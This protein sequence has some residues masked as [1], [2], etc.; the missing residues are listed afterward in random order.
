MDESKEIV[1]ATSLDDAVETGMAFLSALFKPNDVVLLRPIES[2]TEDDRKRSRV[3]Y[4]NTDYFRPTEL[5]L[6]VHL[7]KQL[8]ASEQNNTNIFFGTCPRVGTRGQ[9]DLA[10]QIRTVRTLWS[11]IDHVTVDEAQQ[12]LTRAGLPEPSILVN[13]GNGVHVYWLLDEPYLI[14]DAGDPHRVVTEWIELDGGRKKPRKYIVEEG[15]RVYLDHC[16]HTSRLSPKAEHLQDVLFGIAQ[17]IDGDHTTDLSRLLRI[18]G[19]MNRK[20]Q[21]NGDKPIPSALIH[22]EP[23]RMYSLSVFEGLKRESPGTKKVKK[24][25]AMPLPTTR[26]PSASKS[27]RLN[28]LVAA[29]E[30]A[31]AGN[32][33][34]ADFAVCC[35]AIRSGIAKDEVW[36]RVEGVGK[37]A[38]S[39]QRYFD[40]TWANAEQGV[41]GETYDRMTPGDTRKKPR[42]ENATSEPIEFE[43]TTESSEAGGVDGADAERRPTICVEPSSTPV[44]DT[45]RLIT[46]RLLTAGTC[47]SRADQ[48]V[49]VRDNAITPVLS[50]A[51]LAGLLNQYV[52]FY[53][54]DGEEGQYKPLPTNYANTWL[55]HHEQRSRLPAIKLF[56]RNPVFTE[57]WRLV[58]PGFDK[59][60]GIYYSGPAVE[61]RETTEHL[62][63]LLRDFCFKTPGDRTNYIA[64]L[65]TAILM[66]RFVGSKPAVLFNGNQPELGKSILAQIISILRDGHTTE[67]ATY[68]ANDEELEKRLGAVVRRGVTTIIIDNAKGQARNP[69]I[70]S[71]C[72][73]RSITDPVLSFRLLGQSK[74]IRAE[75][76]HIFCITANTPDVSRDLVTR[77]VVVNL[78]FEGAPD[79]R[80]FSIVDPE[81]YAAEHRTELLG[82]LIGMVQRWKDSE[83]PK[84]DVR[85]R[86]NKRDW[87]TIVGGILEVCGEPDFLAN[88]GDAASMLDETRRDFAELV[89]ILADHAQGIWTAAELAELSRSHCLLRADLGEGSPRSLSTKMGVIAGRFVDQHFAVDAERSAKF[90]RQDGRK[91][92]TYQVFIADCPPPVPNVEASAERLPNLEIAQRSAP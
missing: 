81:G 91:G 72:L 32:R 78:E 85:S 58:T 44:G 49:L 21:R 1:D 38:E 20:N 74:E 86:F 75:N 67:T 11:D 73:E 34:E 76:S 31:E 51:E 25:A 12:R 29:S 52:E 70:E 41:R 55:H 77:S 4:R 62:D 60:S 30:I 7:R 40:H 27:D 46:K 35:F 90:T 3:D 5:L 54:L 17:A 19:S 43:A 28:E 16:K 23:S 24:V 80:A 79:Q 53:F 82:E 89:A 10:W 88:A 9:F 36:S 15:E 42:R 69:R 2:W 26:K 8:Q 22:C 39:G 14:D 13:S 63:A 56:T 33:S 47:F 57:D 48:L 87:G 59:E 71:A 92:K 45:M 83:M 68:N 64:I 84:A 66:P 18:P 61:A 65:L 6:K 50:A 37:F